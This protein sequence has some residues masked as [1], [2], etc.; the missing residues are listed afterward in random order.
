MTVTLDAPAPLPDN[1]PHAWLLAET[2]DCVARFVASDYRGE[3][4]HHEVAAIFPT[5]RNIEAE[6]MPLRSI[7]LAIA[8]SSRTAGYTSQRS[9]EQPAANEPRHA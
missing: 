5:A 4:T 1:L 9:P 2:V 7:F 6:P 8:K 3:A